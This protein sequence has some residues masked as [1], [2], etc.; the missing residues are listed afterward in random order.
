M[1]YMSSFAKTPEKESWFSELF[2]WGETRAVSMTGGNTT[3]LTGASTAPEG[4]AEGSE[5]VVSLGS[6]VM[7]SGGIYVV[8]Y[9]KITFYWLFLTY[10]QLFRA[11]TKDTPFT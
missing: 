9:I 11:R 7:G 6:G 5:I 4:I 1:Y 3:S 8:N 2:W 10:T